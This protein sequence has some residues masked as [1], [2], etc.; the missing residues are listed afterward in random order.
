MVVSIFP[1][2]SDNDR[3]NCYLDCAISVFTRPPPLS[4]RSCSSTSSSLVLQCSIDFSQID[5][6][7]ANTR[8]SHI[9]RCEKSDSYSSRNRPPSRRQ[10]YS[11]PHISRPSV[12]EKRCQVPLN[13][14][15]Q[16]ACFIPCLFLI[17]LTG[18]LAFQVSWPSLSSFNVS[19]RL[20]LASTTLPSTD[21]SKYVY[22][23]Q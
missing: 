22:Y 10:R 17:C 3:T 23:D 11:K 21:I 19:S 12:Y 2:L 20:I 16:S 8:Y 18:S 14:A 5:L 13:F 1:F 6:A 15:L 7:L 4:T 9:H